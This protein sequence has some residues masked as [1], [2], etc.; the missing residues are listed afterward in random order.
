MALYRFICDCGHQKEIMRPMTKAP[1]RPRCAGCGEEMARDF[2]TAQFI[3]FKPY[4]ES[5]FTGEP[6]R[7]E[8]PAQRDRL[9]K[10]HHLTYD[11]VKYWQKPQ[12][13]SVSDQITLEDVKAAIEQ[14]PQGAGREVARE[15]I[16][17][18]DDEIARV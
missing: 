10:E 6:I 3:A 11:S 16:A 13:S 18:S 4:T 8:S 1:K 14:D 7:I 9:L 17:T 15:R 12:R 5:N 2:S